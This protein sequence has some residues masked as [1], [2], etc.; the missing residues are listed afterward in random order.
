MD[1]ASLARIRWRLRGAWLWPSFVMLTVLDAIIGHV[2]P[3]AGDGQGPVSAALV[4]LLLNLLGVILL[5]RPFGALVRRAHR[6][7]PRVVAQDY[8][9]TIV[10]LGVTAILLTAGLAHHA[11]VTADGNARS[12]A[13]TRAQAWIG[14]HAPAEFRRNVVRVSTYEIKPGSIYRECV[15]SA[16]SGRTYCVVVNTQLPFASSVSFAGYESNA[17]FA[18]GAW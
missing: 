5:R 15:P 1:G 4:G 17:V 9:G 12:D 7:L 16:D 11:R 18:Q 14:A 13:I 6:D 3:P 8:G 10:V 2:L